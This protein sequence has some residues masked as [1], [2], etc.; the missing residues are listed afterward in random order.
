M[1]ELKL[2]LFILRMLKQLPLFDY[3]CPKCKREVKEKSH[4]CPYCGENYGVPLRVPPKVLKD[5]KA[6]E[7]YVHKHILPKIS[8]SQRAYLTQFFTII[9]SDE[10]I[11]QSAYLMVVM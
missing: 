10:N 4:K 7:E 11:L 8:A 5:P 6:L 1:K 9:F 2:P 3:I